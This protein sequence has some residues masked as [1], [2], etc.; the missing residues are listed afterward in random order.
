L[1]PSTLKVGVAHP[2]PTEKVN[3]LLSKVDTV[4][5]LEELEPLIE[6]TVM[7]LKGEMDHR[8]EVIGKIQGPLARTGDYNVHV[9][10]SALR[11]VYREKVPQ[12]QTAKGVLEQAQDLKVKRLNTFCVGCPHRATYYALNQAIEKLGYKEH[13]VIITGDIGCTILGMNEPFQSC[14]TEISMGSSISLAQGFKYAGIK[15]PVVATIGDG[16]FFHA[17]IPALLNASHNNTNLTVIILDNHWASM[18]G[19]QPHVGS[20]DPSYAE[21]KQVIMVEE[22]VRAAGIKHVW[23]VNPYQTKKMIETVMEAVSSPE[24]SVVISDAECA[25]QKR[26]KKTGGGSLRVK[27][28]KCVNLEAC[29]HSCIEVLG[30]PAVGRGEDGKAFIDPSICTA[31][32]LCHHACPHGAI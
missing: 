32:G 19:M 1:K 22:I 28:E 16:T 17:G 7:A 12:P 31:C 9:V 4:V 20:G 2:L 13:E 5:V 29:E 18:T 21:E 8:V 6:E 24:I 30:C 15:T 26:R 25:I 10:A 3:A 27:P 14:W 23:R 11:E